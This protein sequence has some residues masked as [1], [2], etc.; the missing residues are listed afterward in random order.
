M[1]LTQILFRD[2]WNRIPGVVAPTTE[3]YSNLPKSYIRRAMRQV[4]IESSEHFS[5]RKILHKNHFHQ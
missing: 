3:K 2:A 5:M 1:R 4:S